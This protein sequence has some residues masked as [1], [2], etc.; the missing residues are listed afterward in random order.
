MEA[1]LGGGGGGGGLWVRVCVVGDLG[2]TYHISW[3][4][5]RPVRAGEY[6]GGKEKREGRKKKDKDPFSRRSSVA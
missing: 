6:S 5:K 2:A 4:K 3:R 1:C